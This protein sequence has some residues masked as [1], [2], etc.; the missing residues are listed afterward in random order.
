MTEIE[1]ES[2]YCC[3]ACVC[4]FFLHLILLLYLQASQ[5]VKGNLGQL[6]SATHQAMFSSMADISRQTVA[7]G[8]VVS[9]HPLRL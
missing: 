1:S 6:S 7:N 2:K 4:L 9:I 5:R 3:V 8:G